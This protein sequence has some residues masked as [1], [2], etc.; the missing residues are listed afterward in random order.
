ML[1]RSLQSF[2]MNDSTGPRVNETLTTEEINSRRAFQEVNPLV[3]S[4]HQIG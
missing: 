4:I 3:S 1:T 2:D